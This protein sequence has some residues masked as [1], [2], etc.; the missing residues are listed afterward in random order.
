MTSFHGT[1]NIV[2]HGRSNAHGVEL[3]RGRGV[4]FLWVWR[5]W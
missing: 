4:I 5:M 3:M 2:A 1:L